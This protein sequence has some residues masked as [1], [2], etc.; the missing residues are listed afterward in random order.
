MENIAKIATTRHTCKAFDPTKK[1]DAGKLDALSTVLRFAPSSVNSQPWHFVIAASD[2]GKGLIA[3]ATQGGYS[4]NEPKVRNASHVVV[5][6]A[7]TDIDDAHLAAVLA[8]EDADGRF[9]SPEAKAGQNTSR[10]FYAGLHRNELKDASIWMEKQ[11]YLALGTLL[12]G[13]GALEIDA[14]PMEGFDQAILDEALGLRDRGLTSVV[15][16]AL[17]YRSELDFNAK[18]PKSRLPAEALISLI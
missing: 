9:V 4:Y 8:Q 12:Q 15:L 5:L 18:L 14:C 7:R 16:V 2:E 3:Q 10:S 1:I 17:G 11:V 6:C 13:A